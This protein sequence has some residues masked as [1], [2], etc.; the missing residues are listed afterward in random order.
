MIGQLFLFLLQNYRSKLG[1]NIDSCY[2][3]IMHK[4]YFSTTFCLFTILHFQAQVPVR[5][6]PMH[7]NIFENT[8]VRI[9]DVHI[10]RGDTTLFHIH[11]TPSVF[12]ILSNVKTG[13][14][15][16]SEEDRSLNPV[17]HFGNIYFEGF[18]IKPRIHRVWNEDTAAFHVMDIELISKKYIAID[19][20][21][22]QEAFVFLFEEKPVRG[23]QL[24]LLPEKTVHILG[25]KADI[26]AV[27][28]TDFV[29]DIIINGRAFKRKGEFVYIP[30]ETPVD[31]QNNGKQSAVFAFFEIK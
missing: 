29:Q 3:Y 26:L 6:E 19:S 18:Y 15:V 27:L 31:F 10:P 17:P 24:N 25:R 11:A 23:Y 9:L 28:Q 21:L 5:M 13:S 7:H 22:H 1:V 2:E 12:L 4:F 20:P 14:Q 16:I 8:R 30:A